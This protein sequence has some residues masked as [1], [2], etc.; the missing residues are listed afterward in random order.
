MEG[1]S[2][3]SPHLTNGLQADHVQIIRTGDNDVGRRHPQRRVQLREKGGKIL[4]RL[5]IT[6]ALAA[7]LLLFVAAPAS[8]A[9][10]WRQLI[11]DW[12]DGRIDRQYG[13]ACYREAVHHLPEDAPEAGE[14]L[15]RAA[16]ATCRAVP[17]LARRSGR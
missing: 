10:C 9:P 8:A 13:C 5:G 6:T 2:Y 11:N 17:Q 14:S 4:R 16:R 7:L 15:R 12:Y 3:H 1:G